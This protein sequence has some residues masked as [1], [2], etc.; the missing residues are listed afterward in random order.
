MVVMVVV[1]V[2][3]MMVMEVVVIVLVVA[4]AVAVMVLGATCDDDGDHHHQQQQHQ[5]PEIRDM[6]MMMMMMVVVRMIHLRMV[7]MMM[8]RI[9]TSGTLLCWPGLK[10]PQILQ[11]QPSLLALRSHSSPIS[12]RAPTCAR[13]EPHVGL[14]L[15]WEKRLA[16]CVWTAESD[17]SR[18]CARGCVL[19]SSGVGVN[20]PARK[21]SKRESAQ[22]SPTPQILTLRCGCGSAAA[23]GQWELLESRLFAAED[24]DALK[25]KDSLKPMKPRTNSDQSTV[26]LPLNHAR[27]MSAYNCAV[28]LL[29]GV[30]QTLPPAFTCYPM[31]GTDV[32]RCGT[33]ALAPR[34]ITPQRSPI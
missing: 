13:L 1:V 9:L 31:R 5:H 10:P 18:L 7:M 26:R 21:P 28:W 17:W 11:Q 16:S 33:R 23:A 25:I 4:A 6:M 3:M 8:V 34:T 30:E 15:L 20:L 22:I 12:L 32:V 29:C 24:H 14:Y 27:V 2:M 19:L